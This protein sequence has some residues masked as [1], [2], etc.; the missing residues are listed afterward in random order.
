MR[1]SLRAT[2]ELIDVGEEEVL[3]SCTFCLVLF[4][5]R[6]QLLVICAVEVNCDGLSGR[7]SAN[8]VSDARPISILIFTDCARSTPA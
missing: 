5:G 7:I 1:V 3:V 2:N 6:N 4:F 8:F